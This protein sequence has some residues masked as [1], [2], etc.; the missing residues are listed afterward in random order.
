MTPKIS[1]LIPMYNRKHYIEQC[2]NSALNQ[3][4][5]DFEIIVR[6]DGSSDGSADFVAQRYAAEI[7]AGKIK[8]F[9]N[10][11]NL[12][13][14]PTVTALS[15]DATGK[16]ITFLHSDDMY[17][18][19]ALAH[20]Y[21][22]AEKY[23]ADVVHCS[24]FLYTASDVVDESTIKVQ[25]RE[26]NPVDKITVMPEAPLKRV[27]EWAING[28]F[29][30]YQYNFFRRDLVLRLGMDD[31]SVFWLRWILNAKVFVKTPEVTYLRRD[32][33][34]SITNDHGKFPFKALEKFI[35]SKINF[36]CNIDKILPEWNMFADYPEIQRLIKIKS[37]IGSHQWAIARRGIY[38]DGISAE[39]YDS[40]ENTFRKHFG[41]GG[42]MWQFYSICCSWFRPTNLGT[43]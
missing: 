39:L 10:E 9:R 38:K 36:A 33:L 24:Y 20:F 43:T 8:L 19:H 3:T 17:L 11:K 29:I 23:S 31:T 7:S 41:V 16:Y 37:L 12:G 30:D 1:V 5:Q 18:P 2:I 32:V 42:V 35:D 26:T 4:F 34:D 14:D 27:I 40:V 21:A 13:E 15:K 25:C 22:V 6:D 28:T